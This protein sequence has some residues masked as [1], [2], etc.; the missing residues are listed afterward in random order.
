MQKAR[1]KAFAILARR[2][3]TR[4]EM[5]EKLCRNFEREVAER[6]ADDLCRE[7]YIDDEKIAELRIEGYVRA[8]KS[9]REISDRLRQSG[10]DRELI[11]RLVEEVDEIKAVRRLL[12]KRYATKM[13]EEQKVFMSLRRKGFSVSGIKAAMGLFYEDEDDYS[14]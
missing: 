3:H 14:S 6:V 13:D 8:H 4:H 1:S 5:I 7:G 11:E 10:I 2:D 12:E 9:R